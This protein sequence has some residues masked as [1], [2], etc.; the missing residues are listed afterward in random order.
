MTILS[1][2]IIIGFV[3]PVLLM[4]IVGL[5]Q[6]I[7]EYHHGHHHRGDAPQPAE[8]ALTEPGLRARPAARPRVRHRLARDGALAGAGLVGNEGRIRGDG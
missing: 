1:V 4:F 6:L 2:S 7:R 8:P 3:I 5:P